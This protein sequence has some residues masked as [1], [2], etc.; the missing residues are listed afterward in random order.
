MAASE[1]AKP[2]RLSVN[3]APPIADALKHL[4]KRN[5]DLTITEAVRRA[6][7]LWKL[8]S[9]EQDKGHRVVVVKGEG[10]AAKFRELSL[11]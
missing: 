2:V 5:S 10:D 11:L 9:D 4:A 3:L 8:V 6:L 7:A 1:R